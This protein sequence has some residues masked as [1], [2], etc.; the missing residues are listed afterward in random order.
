MRAGK[1]LWLQRQV[2]LRGTA[3]ELSLS[4]RETARM[5][6]KMKKTAPVNRSSLMSHPHTDLSDVPTWALFAVL[7]VVLAIKV[8][9][10]WVALSLVT[11][12]VKAF[13][14]H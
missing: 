3:A 10:I 9:V 7:A 8:A 5:T 12:G 6:A 4:T 11:S 13:T 2:K 1:L 14:E